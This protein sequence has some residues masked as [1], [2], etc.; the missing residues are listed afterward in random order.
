MKNIIICMIAGIYLLTSCRTVTNHSDNIISDTV[1]IKNNFGEVVP[2]TSVDKE[3]IFSKIGQ[4][5]KFNNGEEVKLIIKNVDMNTAT[6]EVMTDEATKEVT[7]RLV[8]K[9]N[10]VIVFTKK[11]QTINRYNIEVLPKIKLLP[12]LAKEQVISTPIFDENCNIIGFQMRYGSQERGCRDEETN[13]IYRRFMFCVD[14]DSSFL[15]SQKEIKYED[16]NNSTKTSIQ[17][18]PNS[19]PKSP[20]DSR[21][22]KLRKMGFPIK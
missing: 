19:T 5:L 22:D 7:I 11:C 6:F 14:K 4:E 2:G 21:K 18:K 8:D 12:E 13:N 10:S 15:N 20:T 17:V 1:I 3:L 16:V 9:N